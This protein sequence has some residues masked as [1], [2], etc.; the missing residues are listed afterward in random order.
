VGKAMT[1]PGQWA[2]GH[3]GE[4]SSAENMRKIIMVERKG[5]LLL[6]RVRA[7]H[8]AFGFWKKIPISRGKWR[9]SVIKPV[10]TDRAPSGSTVSK[11]SVVPRLGAAPQ[12]G[13]TT[14]CRIVAWEA[15]FYTIPY[16]GG[17]QQAPAWKKERYDLDSIQPTPQSRFSALA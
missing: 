16:L 10:I 17:Q 13:T 3:V 2:L 4:V 7:S 15:G 6:R 14:R 8:G 9:I 12:N 1:Y 5:A 11:K